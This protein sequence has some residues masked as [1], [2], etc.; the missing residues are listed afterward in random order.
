MRFGLSAA[1]LLGCVTTALAQSVSV[2]ADIQLATRGHGWVLT[3]AA[4]MTLYTYTKDQRY[5]EPLCVDT[6]AETWPP[7]VA[8]G[9]TQSNVDWSVIKRD[10]GRYQWAFRG[11][12]LYTSSRD[13]AP[14]DMNGDEYQQQW[15]VAVMPVP[16]PPGFNSYKTPQGH[17]LVDQKNM[18][19]YTSSADQAG[20]S[21]CSGECAKTWQPVEAW[22]RARSTMDD[23]SVVDRADGTTQWAYKNQ[24]LYRYAGDFQ[25]G[26]I[27]GNDVDTFTAVILEPPPPVPDW[28]T[29]QNSDAG[30]LLADANGKTLYAYDLPENRAFG[31]GIGR[32][33]ATPHLWDPVYADGETSSIGHWSVIELEDGRHQWTYKGQKLFVHKRDTDPGDLYGQRSTDRYWRTIMADGKVMAGSGR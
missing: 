24:P 13:V 20:L 32:D 25:P 31:I 18:T 9:E 28:I 7:L 6:C 27:A 19:M 8:N 1:Y 29:Y 23:W 10:D 15:Y 2:P 3:D 16:L 21:A 30:R 4:G 12:P 26:E 14:A 22:W 33:M 17:L 11:K 5:S